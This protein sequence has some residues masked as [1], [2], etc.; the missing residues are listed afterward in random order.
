VSSINGVVVGIVTNVRKG[1]VKVKF[2]WLHEEDADEKES[3]W[4]RV[5]TAM[6]GNDMGTFLMP[7]VGD[8][9][10]VAFDHGDFNSPY[11]IGS[12]WNGKDKPPEDDCKKRVIK[13]KS[14]LKITFDDNTA[15]IEID[16]GR[17]ISINGQRIEF[18]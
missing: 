4:A 16:G 17:K 11:V 1:A 5:A 15:E 3:N 18:T 10:L 6:A 14:G 2:P 12:L 9:V 8:E 7:E 13:T